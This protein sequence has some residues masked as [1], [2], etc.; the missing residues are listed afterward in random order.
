MKEQLKINTSAHLTIDATTRTGD[1]RVFVKQKPMVNGQW[2]TVKCSQRGFTPTPTLVLPLVFIKKLVSKN[3]FNSESKYGTHDVRAVKT[4][5]KL[6][7][8]FTLVEMIVSLGLFTIVMFIATSAFL[9][10]VNADRKA[11]A[12]RI[13]AD[14]LNIALED[15]SRRLKTGTSYY[16]GTGGGAYLSTK[17]CPSGDTTSTIFFTDQ[18]G[19]RVSYRKSTT[20][21]EILREIVGGSVVPVTSPEIK[22]DTLNFFV[23][24][25]QTADSIQPNVVIVIKGSLGQ[26]SASSTFMMQTT[27]VQRAYDN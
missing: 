13:A 25:S 3:M 8:G 20:K 1:A 17:N 9:T 11:R 12:V 4:M 27:V 26:G 14:N 2:L 23:A 6:V 21:P 7:S 24:G 16:C 18:D 22:I 19:R 10:I 5:P 15:M